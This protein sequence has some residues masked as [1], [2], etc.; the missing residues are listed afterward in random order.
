MSNLYLGNIRDAKK[1]KFDYILNV[2]DIPLFRDDSIVINIP[3]YDQ[4][5]FN[6]HKFFEITNTLIDHILSLNKKLLVNCQMGISRST[7]IVMAY[8]IKHFGINEKKALQ[9]I[10]DVRDIVNP[11]DGFM[12]QLKRY[13]K[14]MHA[15]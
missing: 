4:S 7:S 11:N 15:D 8:L 3:M 10:E 9:Y 6:I 5:N 13:A 14:R 12:L 2:S 1:G